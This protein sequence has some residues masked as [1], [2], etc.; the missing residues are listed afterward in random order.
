M[1][2]Q[3]LGLGCRRVSYAQEG[4]DLILSRFFHNRKAGFYVDVGAHHPMRYS[5][6]YL[7]YRRGWHGINIDAM[8]GSM[9]LFQRFRSRDVNIEM[10]VSD[11]A[12]ELVFYMFDEPAFNTCSAQLAQQYADLGH[13]VRRKQHVPCLPL[14]SILER[15]AAHC[16]RIDLLS[17]DVEGEDMKALT[18]ND[19][20][21]FRPVFV[22]VEILGMQ[23]MDDVHASEEAKY[24]S[25]QGYQVVAKTVNT[26]FFK[27]M[28][29]AV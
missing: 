26:V 11:I 4:E 7:L 28:D 8:P 24:L 12:G 13:P 25:Q 14:Q 22:L 6:T 16:D 2:L 5:N 3:N 29:V 19:W 23:D 18:S 27:D 10:A 9:K 15:H 17:I 21:R 1:V 20:Q